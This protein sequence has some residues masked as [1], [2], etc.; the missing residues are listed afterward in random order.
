M[1]IESKKNI[2]FVLFIGYFVLKFGL[3][4][5][6][7]S[8]SF[9][10]S[11]MFEVVFIIVSYSLLP[12]KIQ[13]K[14]KSIEMFYL[15]ALILIGFMLHFILKSLGVIIPFDFTNFESVMILILVGPIL[16]EFVFRG[17][18][19]NQLEIIFNHKTVVLMGTSLIFAFAHFI[20]Y[21]FV[22]AE[23]YNFILIQTIYTFLLGIVLG[24][25][26]MKSK[27]ILS[28]ILLHIGFNLGFYLYSILSI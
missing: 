6:W 27:T 16:E 3:E 19:W 1:S 11:Y 23:W 20:A 9:Y 4:A 8:L 21:F 12:K 24:L 5:Y 10:F 22:S 26:M 14:L 28:P 13:L 17:A 25:R 7:R 2:S 18:L 15:M